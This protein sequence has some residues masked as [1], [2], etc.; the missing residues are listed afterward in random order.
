MLNPTPFPSVLSLVRDRRFSLIVLLIATPLLL[1]FARG[2]LPWPCPFLHL[3]GIPCP[4]CGLTRAT[5]L[6]LRGDVK[7]SLAFHAFSPVVVLG[8]GILTS[9]V[10]LPEKPR[11]RWA[12]SL[13]RIERKTGIILILLAALILYW[14]GRVIF[15]NSAFLQLIQR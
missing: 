14:L 9:S 10:L 1:L 5:Y 8:L 6:L 3:T 15:L 4:G 11:A 13:A 12:E 2:A 7:E